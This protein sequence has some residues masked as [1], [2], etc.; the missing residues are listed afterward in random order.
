MRALGFAIAHKVLYE[1]KRELLKPEVIWNI[2]K[3]LNL[4]ADQIIRAETQRAA[5]IRRAFAFFETYDLL[6]CP[7]TIVAAY[8]VEQRYLA[9]CNGV[10]FDSYI[11][12]LAIVYGP[13]LLGVPALSLPAGFTT[14][15]L[16]VGL[17][18]IAPPRGEHRL[19]PAARLLETILGFSAATPIDPRDPPAG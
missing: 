6:L 10:T 15:G 3:G 14:E 18:M 1:T 12:W 4:T 13:T 8:P 5:M 2:E 7:A 9:S 11:D 19:L 17:Q 16:P